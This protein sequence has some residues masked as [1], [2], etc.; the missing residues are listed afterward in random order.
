MV[1]RFSPIALR[2]PSIQWHFSQSGIILAADRVSEQHIDDVY[3]RLDANKV[4]AISGVTLAAGPTGAY[5]KLLFHP[6]PCYV[7]I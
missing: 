7:V 5:K 1:I 6:A 2:D 4:V 3:Q